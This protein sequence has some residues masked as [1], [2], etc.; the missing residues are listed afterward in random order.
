MT[1][2]SLTQAKT[3]KELI[4]IRYVSVKVL[5]SSINIVHAVPA[6]RC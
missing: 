6:A 5:L 4:S 2:I 1:F 3:H